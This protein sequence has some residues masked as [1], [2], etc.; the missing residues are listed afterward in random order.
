MRRAVKLLSVT[1]KRLTLRARPSESVPSQGC[2]SQSTGPLADSLAETLNAA[3]EAV[4]VKRQERWGNGVSSHALHQTAR[5]GSGVAAAAACGPPCERA[6]CRAEEREPMCP[7]AERRLK[8]PS[9]GSPE[10]LPRVREGE[11][12]S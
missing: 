5:Q 9:A 11:S 8:G 1:V 3:L 7:S 2:P 4:P 10:A 6:S 12:V